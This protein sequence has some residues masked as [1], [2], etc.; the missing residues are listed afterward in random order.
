MNRRHLIKGAVATASLFV[1]EAMAP[2]AVKALVPLEA[3]GC[4][5]KYPL[6][7]G[8]NCTVH[9]ESGKRWD[10]YTFE[11]VCTQYRTKP[12]EVVT[13][14]P[15]EEMSCYCGRHR[16]RKFGRHYMRAGERGVWTGGGGEQPEYEFECAEAFRQKFVDAASTDWYGMYLESDRKWRAERAANR[17]RYG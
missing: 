7:A 17:V 5:R 6:A 12:S 16:H 10:A 13:V 8:H 11:D 1:C 14:K 3:C 15:G 4:V 2:A 9:D